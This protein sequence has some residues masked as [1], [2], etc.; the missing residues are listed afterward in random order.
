[1]NKVIICPE[2]SE[3]DWKHLH[4]LAHG[5]QGTHMQGS[6]RYYCQTCG[7]SFYSEEG[8]KIGLDFFLD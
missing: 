1:M 7:K 4:D 8:K 3:N 2:C 6:E 5:I